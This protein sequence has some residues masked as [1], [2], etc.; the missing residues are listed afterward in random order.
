MFDLG[1]EE[2]F[3]LRVVSAAIRQLKSRKSVREDEIQPEMLK[4]LNVRQ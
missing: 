3:T 1:K 2:V 4:A